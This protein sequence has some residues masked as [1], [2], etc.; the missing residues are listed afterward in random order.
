MTDF[1]DTISSRL[2][3]GSRNKLKLGLFGANLSSGKN[4]TLVVERWQAT[5]NHNLQ[6]A[7]LADSRGLEFFLPIGRWRGHGGA[8]DY[9][10][11]SFETLTWAAALLASTERIR[12]FG[13]VHVPLFHPVVAAK[14]TITAD[15][16]GSGRFGLNLV[17]GEAHDEKPMFG[18][19]PLEHDERY[20]QAQEW[21]D[22]VRRLWSDTGDFDHTGKY[23]RLKA[24]HT[25][26]KPVGYSA[27]MVLNA[28]LS[29]VG[30]QFAARNCDGFFTV[31]KSS[32]FDEASGTI[33]PD[34][35]SVSDVVQGARSRAGALGRQLSVFTNVN[36]I[37]RPSQQEAIDYYHYALEEHADWPAVDHQLESQQGEVPDPGSSAYLEAETGHTTISPHW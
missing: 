36:V 14:M 29:G 25:S 24:C 23:Y 34:I 19:P 3:L 2:A 21:L 37:C 20:V 17:V 22:I 35:A 26:P 33:T 31:V 32:T 28:G 30:Q 5:W 4:A 11:W 15:H 7:R 18:S 27:P 8:T 6:L 13:T 1:D 12:V 16:V 10:D 9:Q